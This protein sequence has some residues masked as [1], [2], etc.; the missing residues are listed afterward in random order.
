MPFLLPRYE[1]QASVIFL[2]G[3]V[4]SALAAPGKGFYV[5]LFGISAFADANYLKYS[6]FMHR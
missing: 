4:Q 3:T 5:I 1:V 6:N 2:L